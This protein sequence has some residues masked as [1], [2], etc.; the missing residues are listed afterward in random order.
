MSQKIIKIY[1]DTNV[2]IDFM[3]N[4]NEVV[5]SMKYLFSQRRKEVLFTS[6]LAITQAISNLQT[7]KKTRKA[8][9]KE[10]ANEVVDFYHSKFSVI[11]LTMNDVLS[12]KSKAGDDLED[13]IHYVLSKKRKC[14][15][16][17]TNNV[18]DFIGYDDV[19]IIKPNIKLLKTT[20]F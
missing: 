6:S 17:I 18:A 16:I 9:T 19:K 1:V 11:D 7:K 8:F 2:L 5:N 10:E 4:Q 13:C 20:I 14:D 3:T 12:A 15:A